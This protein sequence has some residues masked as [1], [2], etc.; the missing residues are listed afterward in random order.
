MAKTLHIHR[1]RAH[2]PHRP[3][4]IH[5]ETAVLTGG[6][7]GSIL[8]FL[9]L[10]WVDRYLSATAEPDMSAG[11]LASIARVTPA[12]RDAALDDSLSGRWRMA[13]DK[14]LYLVRTNIGQWVTDRRPPRPIGTHMTLLT[15]DHGTQY[16]CPADDADGCVVVQR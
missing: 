5:W 3:L 11:Y 15:S 13:Q 4:H 14:P 8:L 16:L 6:I 10:V 1:A 12:N 2:K 7:V 9:G